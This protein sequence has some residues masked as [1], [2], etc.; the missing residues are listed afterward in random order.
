VGDQQYDHANGAECLVGSLEGTREAASHSPAN[1]SEEAD[2]YDPA[3]HSPATR[4][5]LTSQLERRRIFLSLRSGPYNNPFLTVGLSGL[6]DGRMYEPAC[7]SLAI[8]SCDA[9]IRRV[10]RSLP[11]TLILSYMVQ[12]YLVSSFSQSLGR[13]TTIRHH[14]IEHPQPK[15]YCTPVLFKASF[16]CIRFNLTF[17]LFTRPFHTRR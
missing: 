1:L 6:C 3:N 7:R 2:V 9:I 14:A 12:V 13:R 16:G 8:Y 4:S 10:P 15:R 17:F 5:I 11:N